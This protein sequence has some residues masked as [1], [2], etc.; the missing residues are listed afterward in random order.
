MRE[1][2]LSLLKKYLP[3]P[4]R[5]SGDSNV[6]TKCPFHKDGQEKKPSFSINI[7][8]AI[9]HCF[10]C[11][12]AG[13]IRR[14]LRM[15]GISRNVIDSELS[16]IQPILEK[17][18]ELLKVE[19]LN[20]FGNTDPF[21]ADYILPEVILGVYEWM[22]L[23]LI[24]DGFNPILLKD[25]EIGFDR[26]NSRITYPLRDMYGNL[27]GFSGGATQ[28]ETKPKYKVY[29]GRRSGL[30]GE[31]IE[32]DF[33]T[34]FDEQFSDYKCENHDFLW[35]YNR[36]YPRLLSM[37]DPNVNVFVVE[38]FKACLWMIQNGY[39]N[40]VALMGSYI[41]FKQQQLLHRLGGNIILCLDNDEAGING[42]SKIG[43]LLWK[44]MYGR[45][46]V[47]TYPSNDMNTQPDDYE[48]EALHQIINSSKT[49]TEYLQN[50]SFVNKTKEIY[51]G[52]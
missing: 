15:V 45:I 37:S 44:P 41:S 48:P 50:R 22:P 47:I 29:Q 49:F 10:T 28:Q 9:F 46:R 21:R 30:N 7:E 27:A 23:K 20:V 5:S 24:E 52:Y 39:I 32:G 43:G 3:G 13:D 8:K 35:N 6:I 12:E 34:W 38:G 25:M 40:T 4:F 14:L 36:V 19:K 17:H 1:H 2:V 31:Y 51:Y 33:G 11:H 42:T 18:K 16:Q 26:T